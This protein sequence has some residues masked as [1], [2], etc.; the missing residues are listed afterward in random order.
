MK[1]TFFAAA[2]LATFT[3]ASCSESSTENTEATTMEHGD[4]HGAGAETEAMATGTV[5]ETPKFDSVAQPLQTQIDQLVDQYLDLKNALVASD[6]A[7]TKAAA[8]EVLGTAKAMP[9]ATLTTDEKAYAEEKTANVI[10]GAEAIATATDLE[11]QR[12]HLEHLSEAVFSLAKAFNAADQTLYYQHCPMALNDKGA[13]W[14][15]SNEEIR[16][17]YF[18]EKML[19]CGSTE[20]VYK[21]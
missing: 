9:V 3:F 16:N 20:E 18:G 10:G 1:K 6:V 5:V 13:Y 15:S 4:M 17:P 11:G 21:Q 2:L 12:A 14:L 7:A 8:N 19:K